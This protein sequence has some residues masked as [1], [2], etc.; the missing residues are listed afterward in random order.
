MFKKKLKPNDIINKYKAR[1]VAK[2]HKQR[3][4]VK[5]FDTNSPVTRIY[6]LEYCL[7]FLNL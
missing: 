5:Y 7:P 2:G 6:L 4:H 1:L 3:R